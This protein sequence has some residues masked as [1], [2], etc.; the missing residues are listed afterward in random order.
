M[1]SRGAST[2]AVPAGPLTGTA[3][4]KAGPA[5]AATAIVAFGLAAHNG[6]RGRGPDEKGTSLAPFF[7]D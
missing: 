3:R 5:A 1:D 7:E 4:A 6:K 2:S